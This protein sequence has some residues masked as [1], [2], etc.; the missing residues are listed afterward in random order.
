MLITDYSNYS[1]VSTDPTLSL[2]NISSS[3]NGGRYFGLVIN[4]AGIEV[5]VRNVYFLPQFLDEP[6]DVLTDINATVSL[7][8]AVDGSPIPSI[9][10]QRLVNESFEDLPGENQTTLQFSP[11]SYGDAGVYRC[12]ISNTVN[13]TVYTEI[14]R[15]AT[16]S[17]TLNH[18]HFFYNHVI[19]YNYRNSVTCRH[20][21]Y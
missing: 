1:I 21:S 4:E 16:V 8:V 18:C 17:G 15:A 9:Q 6:D 11:V 13:G 12:V 20:S 10:W 3:E 5:I 2:T 19:F 14:S 7:F